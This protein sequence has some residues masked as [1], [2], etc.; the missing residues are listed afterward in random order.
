M[1]KT[2]SITTK[3]LKAVRDNIALSLAMYQTNK[4]IYYTRYNVTG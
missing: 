2:E 3:I 1:I 4:V